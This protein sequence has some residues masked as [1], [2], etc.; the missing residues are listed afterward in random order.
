MKLILNAQEYTAIA[1]LLQKANQFCIDADKRNFGKIAIKE[2]FPSIDEVKIDMLDRGVTTIVHAV[3]AV[4]MKRIRMELVNGLKLT[5]EQA[6]V[7]FAGKD[8]EKKIFIFR[9]SE[10]SGVEAEFYLSEQDNLDI[11]DMYAKLDK[12]LD[13]VLEHRELITAAVGMLKAVGTMLKVLDGKLKTIWK[14]EK[15]DTS[16]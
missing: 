15:P 7:L 3:D 2:A 13:V 6:M 10:E 5:K 14:K 9:Y 4:K 1:G 8:A 11:L 16:K 12:T